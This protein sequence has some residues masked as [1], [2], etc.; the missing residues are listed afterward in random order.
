MNVL[1]FCWYYS[2]FSLQYLLKTAG[3]VGYLCCCWL[4]YYQTIVV[5]TRNGTLGWAF[6]KK[7][8]C[9][10]FELVTNCYNNSWENNYNLRIIAISLFYYHNLASHK[11]LLGWFQGFGYASTQKSK[12]NHNFHDLLYSFLLVFVVL[13]TH[14]SLGLV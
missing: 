11:P 3:M 4:Y 12:F 14:H 2:G 1:M 5:P 9:N 8:F 6:R 7:W 10:K 13:L